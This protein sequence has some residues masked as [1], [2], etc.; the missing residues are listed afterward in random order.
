L[1]NS[2]ITS[3]DDGSTVLFG[4]LEVATGDLWVANAGDSRGIISR[5]GIAVGLS[6][7]HKPDRPDERERIQKAGGIVQQATLFG[8]HMGPFRVYTGRRT[9]GL[10]VSRGLG[11]A[12]LKNND[13]VIA[14]PEIRH[15]KLTPTDEFLIFATD[16]LWD[17]FSNQQACDFVRKF[18][19]A[20]GATRA[21][22]EEVADL[23]VTEA[24]RQGS[25]DNV[26]AM[27]VYF[28]DPAVFTGVEPDLSDVKDMDTS[29]K[30]EVLHH[31][32]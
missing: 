11:D 2:S 22:P 32:V 26:T 17:V 19:N 1:R 5:R 29:N 3:L 12:H 7:D 16:G 13:L 21:D 4:V 20:P 28:T 9:G 27:I 8:K 31:S 24:I 14:M 30:H 23:L 25:L 10:A 18:Y 15:F 6:E